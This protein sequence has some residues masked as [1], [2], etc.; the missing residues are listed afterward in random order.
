MDCYLCRLDRVGEDTPIN[1]QEGETVDYR[2]VTF[3]D[4]EIMIQQD[5]IPPP[6]AMRY[7]FVKQ[8]LTEIIGEE[9]WLQPEA[10]EIS[11][12]ETAPQGGKP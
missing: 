12:L 3:R 10:E 8:R 7:G 5:R 6:C 4:F 2:W 11:A 1:L 9:A